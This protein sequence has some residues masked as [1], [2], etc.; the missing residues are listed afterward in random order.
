M[1]R[2]YFEQLEVWQTGRQL[3]KKVYNISGLFPADERYGLTQ[4]I[5]RACISVNCNLAEGSGRI[6]G[7]EQARF[8]EIAYGSL[9]ETLNLLIIAVDLDY[10]RTTDEMEIR[11]LFEELGNKL[12]ALRKT[13]LSRSS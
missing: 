9:L 4:Q 3:I 2:F 8:T 5:R 10:I 7:K 6:T 12:N 11:P 13:Q 1:R